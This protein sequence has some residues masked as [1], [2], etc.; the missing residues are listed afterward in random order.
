M[1]PPKEFYVAINSIYLKSVPYS[2]SFMF[3]SLPILVVYSLIKCRKE[4]L[5]LLLICSFPFFI[6]LYFISVNITGLGVAVFRW[7]IRN[8]LG[9][10]MFK[11]FY[12][13]L[14]IGFSFFYALLIAVAL[15]GILSLK[16][17]KKVKWLIIGAILI[18]FILPARSLVSGYLVG[19]SY[20]NSF[21]EYLCVEFTDDTM[22]AIDMLSN[23]K[24]YGRVLIFPLSRYLFMTQECKNNTYYVGIPY[25]KPLSLKDCFEGM[26]AF[27]TPNYP[28]LPDVIYGI[29]EKRRYGEFLEILS[30]LNVKYIYIYN[31]LANEHAQMFIY[32]YGYI[33]N[34]KKEFIN[35]LDVSEK[36]QFGDISI[37]R[38][39]QDEDYNQV[40]VFPILTEVDSTCWLRN[41]IY[42]DYIDVDNMKLIS[43]ACKQ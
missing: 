34:L 42:S 18:P 21:N 41:L 4:H 3:I 22:Q 17:R 37:Y 35:S 29:V 40:S 33:D 43:V 32:K 23:Q 39:N 27:T 14:S 28:T 9:F 6:L 19:K 26:F 5:K 31:N 20:T 7:A 8:I 16:I 13:K 25:I 15:Y 30:L 11:N 24:D 12:T 36:R 10:M 1:L 38:L 2:L